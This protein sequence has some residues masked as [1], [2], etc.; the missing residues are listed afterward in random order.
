MSC[1][2]KWLIYR[3]LRSTSGARLPL[4][5][6]TLSSVALALGGVARWRRRRG[7]AMGASDVVESRRSFNSGVNTSS[8]NTCDR[9]E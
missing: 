7:V 9:S 6:A 1:G 5:F 2:Q 8:V 4:L 3:L